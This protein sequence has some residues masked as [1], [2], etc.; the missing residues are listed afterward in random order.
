M[1]GVAGEV[2]PAHGFSAVA[3]RSEADHLIMYGPPRICKVRPADEGSLHKCIRPLASGPL[4]RPGLD[5]IRAPRSQINASGLLP[6]FFAGAYDALVHCL[7]ITITNL[8][9]GGGAAQLNAGTRR[10]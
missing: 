5:E 4:L 1:G 8:A 2:S 10:S 9:V 6:A 7:V 3:R